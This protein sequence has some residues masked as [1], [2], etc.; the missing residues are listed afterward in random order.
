M[1]EE[2][3]RTS[4]VHTKHIL[5]GI[6]K[7]ADSTTGIHLLK[8]VHFQ[9]FSF[10]GNQTKRST[11]LSEKGFHLRLYIQVSNV[12]MI[13]ASKSVSAVKEPDNRIQTIK[14]KPVIRK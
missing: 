11:E 3:Y 10:R 12:T 1:I 9:K 6:D 5:T 13:I 7:H 4:Y 2:L 14:G 8:V